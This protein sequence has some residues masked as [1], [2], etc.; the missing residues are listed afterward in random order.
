MIYT[1]L[2]SLIDELIAECEARNIAGS[3]TIYGGTAMLYYFHDLRSTIDVD[4]TFTPYEEIKQVSKEI[5]SRHNV[6]DD[7]FNSAVHDCIPPQP[8]NSPTLYYQGEGLTVFFASKEYLLAM[9]ASSSRKSEKDLLDA[10]TLFNALDL[11]DT[12]DIER[13]ISTYFNSKQFGVQELFFEDIA[14]LAHE[15]K[16]ND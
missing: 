16:Q 4:A 5:A 12:S 3:I 10:A 2:T 1:Q 6:P 9:K 15:L 7:W 14:D 8:D 11:K 13:I